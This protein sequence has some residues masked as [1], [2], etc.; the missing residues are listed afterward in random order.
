MAERTNILQI[1]TPRSSMYRYR[2]KWVCVF[3]ATHHALDT[4]CTSF[5]CLCPNW[6]RV[7]PT[8]RAYQHIATRHACEGALCIQRT[9]GLYTY[10]FIH[11]QLVPVL[12]GKGPNHMA[13]RISIFVSTVY[14]VPLL[15]KCI[16]SLIF[17]ECAKVDSDLG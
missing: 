12:T 15:H 5:T 7:C 2:A 3:T 11:L 4:Y 17:E 16:V 8:C 9:A 13:I 6:E 14:E 1:D 10:C